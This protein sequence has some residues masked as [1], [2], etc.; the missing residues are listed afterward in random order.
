MFCH[1]YPTKTCDW[2]N[3]VVRS[4]WSL[5]PRTK[6]SWDNGGRL[7]FDAFSSTTWQTNA[8]YGTT[9]QVFLKFFLPPANGDHVDPCDLRDQRDPAAALPALCTTGA[10]VRP[11]G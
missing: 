11:N 3:P 6:G 2:S 5:G 4:P 7:L 8:V 10:A 1:W 9:L